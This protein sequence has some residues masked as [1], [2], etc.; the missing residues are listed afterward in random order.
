MC[1]YWDAVFIVGTDE[2]VRKTLP[3][4]TAASQVNIY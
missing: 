1:I 4:T 2:D 3:Y